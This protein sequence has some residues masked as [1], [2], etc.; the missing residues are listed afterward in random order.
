MS[1][2]VDGAVVVA[3]AF[4]IDKPRLCNA[5]AT[6]WRMWPWPPP[7]AWCG[8][9]VPSSSES[10]APVTGCDC[11]AGSAPQEEIEFEV[12]EM[13]M[14]GPVA[15]ERGHQTSAIGSTN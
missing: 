4:G 2:D 13:F 6:A 15:E 14:N 12:L 9:L 10:V 8:R 1:L 3:P 11:I 5:C 7:C